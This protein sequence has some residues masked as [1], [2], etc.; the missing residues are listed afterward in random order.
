MIFARHFLYSTKENIKIE[1][2]AWVNVSYPS[3]ACTQPHAPVS[4][5]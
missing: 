3:A 2:L 5:E 4:L 1:T